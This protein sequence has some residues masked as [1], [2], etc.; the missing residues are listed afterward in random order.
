MKEKGKTWI[1]IQT[2][3][4]KE[5]AVAEF[6][7][8]EGIEYY[9]PMCYE[10]T[11]RKEEDGKCERRLVPAVHNLLFIRHEYDREWCREFARKAEVPVYFIRRERE[12]NE[13]CTVSEAE[14]QNFMHA[15]D[16]E[17]EGTRFIDSETL[18]GKKSVPVRVVKKGP[19]YGLTG[20]FVRYGGKHY[21][22]IEMAQS[23]ALLKVSFTW[24]EIVDEGE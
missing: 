20:K 4:H 15:T 16:P 21:I 3:Y 8:K 5:L 6:L 22:A 24:C 2:V 14:M 9:I 10:L 17:I 1:P 7:K 11:E 19:L 12:G 18:L 23:T 13:F